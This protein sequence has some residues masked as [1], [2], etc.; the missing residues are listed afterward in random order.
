[1]TTLAATLAGVRAVIEP[2]LATGELARIVDGVAEQTEAF[3]AAEIRFGPATIGRAPA[4]AG[5]LER[6]RNRTGVVRLYVSRSMRLEA[7][8]QAFVPLID[9]IDARCR[10]APDLFGLVDRFD[11]T[12]HGGP[13]ALDEEVGALF[14]EIGW[15]AEEREAATY[16]HDYP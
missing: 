10:D 1:M 12:G 7:A 15:R 14:I 3:P 16:V 5:A 8:C 9:A 13:P 6:N 4:V 2:M 11:T